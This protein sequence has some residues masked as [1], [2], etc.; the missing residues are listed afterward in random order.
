MDVFRRVNSFSMWASLLISWILIKIPLGYSCKAL[1]T[2]DFFY[3]VY[4]DLC[5]L[6]TS[7]ERSYQMTLTYAFLYSTLLVMLAS[8]LELVAVSF[9]KIYWPIHNSKNN[10]TYFL[11][12]RGLLLAGLTICMSIN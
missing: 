9:Q 1:Q 6:P 11:K 8:F 4:Y 2:A 12:V 3:R 5:L 7:I 10:L